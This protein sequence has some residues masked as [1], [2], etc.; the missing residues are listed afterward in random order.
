MRIKK[1]SSLEILDSRGVPTL[2]TTVELDDG[3]KG[4]ASVPSG[5]SVGVHEALELRDHDHNRYDGTGVLM[6]KHNVDAII[7]DLLQNHD[8]FDQGGIDGMLIKEDGTKNKSKLGANAILSVS[9]AVAKTAATAR[10][11]ELYEYLAHFFG[12]TKIV[13]P[14]PMVN[15]INGGKHAEQSSDFQEYMLLP[16]GFSKFSEALRATAEVFH[17]M[18]KKLSKKD[19]PTGVG[20]EGGFTYRG[21][22]MKVEANGE[23]LQFLVDAI[24]EAGYVPGTE[25]GLGL[26]AAASSFF[27]KDVYDLTRD[28]KKF[29]R[30]ELLTY[31][32]DLKIQYPLCSVE[33]AFAEDDWQGF[34]DMQK[35]MGDKLQTV[36]DDL[37]VTSV[38]RLKQGIALQATNAILIKVNQIGTL[39]ETVET[40][41]LAQNAGMQTI[42]SHRS[43]ETEDTFIADLSVASHAGQ[44]KTG[45]MSR[46]ERLSK[47]NRLLEIEAREKELH[48]DNLFYFEFP[49]KTNG[50]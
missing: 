43:G 40:I 48:P 4:S 11:L 21:F 25:I 39:T 9:L 17:T 20:D 42:I 37:Y 36:G 6:A 18:K 33:D 22:T 50:G 23:P 47:Y 46:S 3:T 12:T 45:S 29:T 24:T 2:K 27:K 28:K 5:A 26:D 41:K 15:V 35:K 8:V 38:E 7:S 16:Y 14:V 30:S 10:H 49:Y 13:L 44:I 19:L 1:I 31:Y 32:E 34:V